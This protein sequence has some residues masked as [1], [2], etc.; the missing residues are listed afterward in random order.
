LAWAFKLALTVVLV[1]LCSREMSELSGIRTFL[2]VTVWALVFLTVV[3][4]VRS[5]LEPDPMAGLPGELQQR[6]HEG[7]TAISGLA[8]LLLILCLTLYSVRSQ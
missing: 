5:I 6:F 1:H 2:M 7:P 8:G 4:T 3:P